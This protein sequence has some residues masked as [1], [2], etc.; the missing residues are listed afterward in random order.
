MLIAETASRGNFLS[1][2]AGMRGR[3]RGLQ[4]K[5][6]TQLGLNSELLY[7]K[8][9]PPEKEEEEEEEEEEAEASKSVSLLFSVLGNDSAALPP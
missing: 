9:S 4:R 1:F 7:V 8:S 2:F 3:R 5:H 6:C